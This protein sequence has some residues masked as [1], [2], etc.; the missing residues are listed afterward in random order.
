MDMSFYI[1]NNP[2]GIIWQIISVWWWVFFPLILFFPFKNAWLWWRRE[3]WENQQ[4]YM[5]LEMIMPREVMKPFTSMEHILSTVWSIHSSIEGIKNFKKKWWIGKRLQHFAIEIVGDGQ[6]PHFYIRV[7]REHIDSLKVALF[8]Q[9]PDLEIKEVRESYTRAVSWNLPD[10]RWDMYGF[11]VVLGKPDPYPIKT[12]RQFFEE[13]PENTK[14]EKRIDPINTLLESLNQLMDGEQ[15]WI[16]IKVAPVSSDD[17]NYRVVGKSVINKLVHRSEKKSNL[18][19]DTLAPQK[20][21]DSKELIPPEMK[22]T[23]REREI[24]KAVEDK[25][26]KNAY[27]CHIRCLYFGRKRIFNRSR[28]SLAENYFSSFS[29]PDLNTFKKFGKT[30]TKILHFIIKRRLYLRK[31]KMLRR[32]LLRENPLFPRTGGSFVLSV[33]ELATIFHPPIGLTTVGTMINKVDAR[34]SEA[35]ENL[36]T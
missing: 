13:K 9:Y 14:E 18:I 16:Q 32:Y 26:G 21:E 20:K 36:P 31:R 30:K 11:D 19:A 28:K 10:K 2:L 34:K 22:L 8:S 5:L 24:V 29:M 6:K 23:P 33:E 12:Y 27:L 4:K 17:T 35:P 25:L 3:L 15:I 1:S 7:N